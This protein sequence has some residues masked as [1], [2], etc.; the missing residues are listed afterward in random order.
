MRNRRTDHVNSTVR[1]GMSRLENVMGDSM[2]KIRLMPSKIKIVFFLSAVFSILFYMYL[3]HWLFQGDPEINLETL[4]ET[5][6][7]PA[8]YGGSACGLFYHKQIAL[9]GMSKFRTFDIINA[10]NVHYGTMKP[11]DWEVVIKKLA[12]DSEIQKI[13]ER[14]CKDANRDPGCDLA[15]VIP[16]TDL[17]LPLRSGPLTPEIVKETGAF[18]FYCP[19]YRLIDRVSTYFTEYKKKGQTL[20]SDKLHV[21]YSALVNP[22]VLLLQV[23]GLFVSSCLMFDTLYPQ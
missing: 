11:H 10:K 20:L 3:A 22:E 12:S 4:L 17:A 5:E 23:S 9:S 13:D 7:C 6:K 18:M 21:L 16:R 19:S 2:L 15:R 8:C 14:L 1:S